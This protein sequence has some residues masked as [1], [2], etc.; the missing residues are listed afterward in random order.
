MM[1][2][3]PDR[4][5]SPA[6]PCVALLLPF[7]FAALWAATSA[8]PLYAQDDSP[9]KP[10][11][12]SSS[13]EPALALIDQPEPQVPGLLSRWAS[14]FNAGF[15]VSGLHDSTT[16]YSTLFTSAVGYNF[17]D[18]FSADLSFPVYLYRLAPNLASN[19]PANHLLVNQR[20]ELGD[21]TFGLHGQWS[22][23]VFDYLGTFAFTVPTGDHV[24]GLS[25]G[26]VTLDYT[27]HFE[28]TYGIFTPDIEIGIGDSSELADR[29][30]TLN[31][32]SL[33]ALAH[34]QAGTSIN[35]FRNIT[36]ATD[37]YEQLPIGDQKIY[38]QINRRRT[39]LTVVTGTNLTED[40]GFIN[41]L[42]IPFSRHIVL[43]GYYSRSL[44]RRT[45][46]TA[47]SLTYTFKTPPRE[48]LESSVGALFR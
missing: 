45:D 17:N 39:T 27:N 11:P 23:H 32:N 9:T 30:I 12:A 41:S 21:M 22:N 4:R 28:H 14:G 10:A 25:T 16:G 46:T 2:M 40:N 33:G 48:S 34:F 26:H 20:G 3:H 7:A 18:H 15:T 19:P 8:V 13:T 24:Y 43:S 37:A 1:D 6:R 42:E 38:Q 44:R 47:L 36:F 5:S 31:Y 35:L 29:S